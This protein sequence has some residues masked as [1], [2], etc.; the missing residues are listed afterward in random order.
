MFII[1]FEDYM[2]EGKAIEHNK[3]SQRHRHHHIQFQ[4]NV[5]KINYENILIKC[6][7]HCN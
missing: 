4:L 7:N 5:I 1:K 6:E 2:I 3:N